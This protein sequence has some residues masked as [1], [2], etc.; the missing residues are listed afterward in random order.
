MNITQLIKELEQLRVKH[1]ELQV[2]VHRDDY[3]AS[4]AIDL[5]SVKNIKTTETE[6]CSDDKLLGDTGSK[7]VRIS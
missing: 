4:D 5:V 7:F 1:G 2:G 3:M 6:Y